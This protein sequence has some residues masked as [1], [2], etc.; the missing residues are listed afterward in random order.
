M[1]GVVRIWTRDSSGPPVGIVELPCPAPVLDVEVEEGDEVEEDEV[2][3]VGNGRS[4]RFWFSM[5]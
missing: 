1:M 2:G 5:G 3:R 4:W